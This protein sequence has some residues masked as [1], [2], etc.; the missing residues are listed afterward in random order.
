[1]PPVRAYSNPFLHLVIHIHTNMRPLLEHRQ[2][3]D[4][5]FHYLRLE[6]VHNVHA[7]VIWGWILAFTVDNRQH[8]ESMVGN[9]WM[10]CGF[11]LVPAS[12]SFSAG[13]AK[14]DLHVF[15]YFK[16]LLN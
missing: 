6:I 14:H 4:L 13:P 3:L 10:R 16:T 7:S 12:I 5:A 15:P 11:I 9:I 1:M 8:L 2:F